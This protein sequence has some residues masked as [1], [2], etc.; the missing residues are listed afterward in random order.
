MRF[1][2]KWL[3]EWV[4]PPVDIDALCEQLTMA[5]LEVDTTGPAAPALDGVVVGRILE[6]APHPQADR[7]TLCAV[8]AGEGKH[9]HIVCGA[10][11]AAAGLVA[12]VALPG[13]IL[14]N[15]AEI[16]ESKIRGEVSQG[17]LCASAELG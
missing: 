2:E 7:L 14:P 3:R 16:T 11:N 13:A 12:P 17:M 8:D 1:S 4:D 6:A 5:G 9:R 15:G 10:P